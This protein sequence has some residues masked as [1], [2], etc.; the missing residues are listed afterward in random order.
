MKS[1]K[2]VALVAV[3]AGLYAVLVWLFQ[4]ISFLAIQFR[5]AEIL[6]PAVAKQRSLAIAFAVGVAIGN[7]VSPFAG[8][9]E[10]AFM[11]FMNIVGGLLAYNVAQL[12]KDQ[13]GKGSY[14]LASIIFSIVIA[15]SVSYMLNAMFNVPFIITLPGLI[16]SEL[17]AMLLGVAL[18]HMIDKRWIWY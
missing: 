8:I 18:F 11:P 9:Y 10:L 16:V 15:L 12:K 13:K 3:F 1:G 2:D 5:V 14:F 4:P 6:K 7:I 17:G